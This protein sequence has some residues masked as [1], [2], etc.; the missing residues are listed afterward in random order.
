MDGGRSP[1]AGSPRLICPLDLIQAPATR[2]Y[3]Y[4]VWPAG[5]G[6]CPRGNATRSPSEARVAPDPASLVGSWR[7]VP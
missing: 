2:A 5:A 4:S 6:S 1:S 3:W 7:P